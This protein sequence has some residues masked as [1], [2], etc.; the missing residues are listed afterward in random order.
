MRRPQLS[1]SS[2]R[3]A[4]RVDETALPLT[5]PRR[6]V[7]T[8]LIDAALGSC[9]HGAADDAVRIIDEH[10]ESRV[11]KASQPLFAGSPRKSEAPATASPTTPPGFRGSVARVP[12][13]TSARPLRH[14]VTKRV[15]VGA[16]SWIHREH[17]SSAHSACRWSSARAGDLLHLQGGQPGAG[18]SA[19][20]RSV[21]H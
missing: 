13:S 21:I 14:R 3:W 6:L 10:L 1:P 9:S 16:R 2:H 17:P 15:I 20:R 18:R 12:R 5:T 4:E 7:V 11:T 19:D 8:D